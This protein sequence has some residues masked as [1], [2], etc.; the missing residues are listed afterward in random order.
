MKEF[1]NN[2]YY[3]TFFVKYLD[4]RK[5]HFKTNRKLKGKC[6]IHLS[7]KIPFNNL[8]LLSQSY[9]IPKLS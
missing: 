9:L 3:Y 6:G 4:N 5:S 7:N 8:V 1:G 2:I